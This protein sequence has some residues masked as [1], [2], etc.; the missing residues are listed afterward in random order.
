VFEPKGAGSTRESEHKG[1]AYLI[2]GAVWLCIAPV[3]R[4]DLRRGVVRDNWVRSC[5]LT[6]VYIDHPDA[7]ATSGPVPT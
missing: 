1:V 6:A 3:L 5:V 2:G 4:R 7:L